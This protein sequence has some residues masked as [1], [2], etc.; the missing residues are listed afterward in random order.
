MADEVAVA[1]VE[2]AAVCSMLVV[3]A[4]IGSGVVWVVRD[5]GAADV[6]EEVGVVAILAVVGEVDFVP[7]LF[8][9]A[10]VVAVGVVV[11]CVVAED[12]AVVVRG[13]VPSMFVV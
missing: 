6:A 12:A 7:V 10:R 1:A 9:R 5:V 4:V 13:A 8:V 11:S 3:R 2:G